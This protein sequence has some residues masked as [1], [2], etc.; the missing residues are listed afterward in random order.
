VGLPA[1]VAGAAAQ[2]EAL[3]R[4]LAQTAEA[5]KKLGL[6]EEQALAR[7]QKTLA[8]RASWQPERQALEQPAAQSIV[9]AR[10]LPSER[11]ILAIASRARQAWP[12]AE[13]ALLHVA[14]PPA[15]RLRLA[16]C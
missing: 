10:E 13:A 8:L 9:A 1:R 16:A 6:P 14:E 4:W 11:L 2:L 3:A 15:E 7:R 12:L 5:P